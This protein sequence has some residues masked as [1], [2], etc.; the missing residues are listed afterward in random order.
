MITFTFDTFPIS[1]NKLY[2]NIQGQ[3][4]RFIS[5]EG[6]AF[7]KMIE[8]RVTDSLQA[9]EAMKYLSSLCGKR[10]AVTITVAS[11][12]WLLKD[13]QTIRKK[14]VSNCEKAL[15]DSIFKAFEE[16]QLELDDSQIWSLNI[17]K[18][19]S[20]KDTTEYSISEYTS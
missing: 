19:V 4:R 5:S 15:T 9:Q 13:G 1:I 3:G 2:V 11:P 6:K 20:D 8:A 17:I 16:L 18:I 14:D 12:S 10:L 7:K